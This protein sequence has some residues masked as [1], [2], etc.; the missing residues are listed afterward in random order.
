MKFASQKLSLVIVA[1]ALALAGCTKKPARPDPA[2][3]V[4]GPQGSGTSTTGMG[5]S[6]ASFGQTNPDG[7]QDRGAGFD[8][9]GQNRTALEAQTVYFDY[10]Q[11]AIKPAEREKLKLAKDYLDKNPTHRLL[12]EGHCDWRGTAEYNLGLG[13]RRAAATKK[14]LQSIGVA[15]DR[16][17]TISKGSLEASKNADEGTMAKDR[18]VNL[19]VVAAPGAAMPAPL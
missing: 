3:T 9:N 1:A 5:V 15:A 19:V 14:Y 18:R 11:S 6:D 17:E 10:D 7:L 2:S 13:D 12:L 4:L 16:L 8:V